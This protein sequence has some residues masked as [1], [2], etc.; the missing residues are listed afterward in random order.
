MLKMISILIAN[1]LTESRSP[2]VF[3]YQVLTDFC[4][5]NQKYS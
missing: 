5:A 2:F 1:L 3:C 4:W